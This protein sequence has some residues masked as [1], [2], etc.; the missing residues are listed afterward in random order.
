MWKQNLM[1]NLLTVGILGSL[2]IIIYCKIKNQTLGDLIKSI[3][4]ATS[5]E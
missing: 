2:A 5:D 4:E 3:R 1:S